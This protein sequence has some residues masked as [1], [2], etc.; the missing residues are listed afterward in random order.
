MF[1]FFYFLLLHSVPK[2]IFIILSVRSS[3]GAVAVW[4]W[5][6]VALAVAAWALAVAV[7]ALAVA[8]AWAWAPPPGA[9][10]WHLVRLTVRRA[11]AVAGGCC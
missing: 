5:S 11:A 1:L 8:V 4:V 2:S 10:V 7:W 3:A 6:P 9:L